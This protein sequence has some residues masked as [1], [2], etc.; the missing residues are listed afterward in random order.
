[1]LQPAGGANRPPLG[2]EDTGARGQPVAGRVQLPNVRH[3]AQLYTQG[4]RE[5]GE[6]SLPT[7]PSNFIRIYQLSRWLA[8]LRAF[9]IKR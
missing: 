7:S 9:V 1:M 2:P 3:L 5:R 6:I 4:D 8:C